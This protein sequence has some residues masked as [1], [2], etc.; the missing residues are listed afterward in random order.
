MP[1]SMSSLVSALPTRAESSS[2]PRL[3]VVRDPVVRIRRAVRGKPHISQ[4]N[5]S[6]DGAQITTSLCSTG[7]RRSTTC[8][9]P[10]VA[11]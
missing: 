9:I 6:A 3:H 7:C 2:T 10:I 8:G 5:N 1:E 4:M 11:A